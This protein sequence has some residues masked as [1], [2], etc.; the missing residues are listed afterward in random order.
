M[1]FTTVTYRNAADYKQ[2]WKKEFTVVEGGI[3]LLISERS[4][5][6][7]PNH[8]IDGIEQTF[9]TTTAPQERYNK[10]LYSRLRR[11]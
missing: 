10:S 11:K 9:S 5:Y 1:E 3:V 2:E 7:V 4:Q 6:F 8:K